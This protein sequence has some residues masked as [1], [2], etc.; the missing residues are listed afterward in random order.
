MTEFGRAGRTTVGFSTGY[1]IVSEKIFLIKQF[2]MR[3]T[4]YSYPC[5]ITAF[6]PFMS[7]FLA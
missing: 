6:L 4:I 5:L 7:K 1:K 2:C 3:Y